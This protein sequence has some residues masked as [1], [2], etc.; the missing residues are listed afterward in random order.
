MTLQVQSGGAVTGTLEE[1]GTA[2][3]GAINCSEG[4]NLGTP[5]SFPAPTITGPITGTSSS[6]AFNQVI[7]NN[8][9]GFVTTF[10]Y[11]FSGTLN[12]GVVTGTLGETL[13]YGGPLGQGLGSAS[14]GG[15]VA[16]PVTLR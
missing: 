1:T 12:N 8:A 7:S 16:M 11:T 5:G 6:L 2:S 15:S 4:I 13:A 14:G 3:A 9:G 10:T